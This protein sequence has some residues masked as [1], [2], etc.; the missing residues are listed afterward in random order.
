MAEDWLTV[1]MNRDKVID[2]YFF[3]CAINSKIDLVKTFWVCCLISKDSSDDV[4]ELS[5]SGKRRKQITI[6]FMASN[7]VARLNLLIEEDWLF[8]SKEFWNA[9]PADVAWDISKA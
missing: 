7:D 2:N 8:A 5:Q 6:S 9:L 4:W 3:D 1:I